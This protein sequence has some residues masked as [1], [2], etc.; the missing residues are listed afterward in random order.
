MKFNKEIKERIVQA[1]KEKGALNPCMRC[2]HPNFS[3]LDGFVNIPLAQEILEGIVILSGTQV[4]CAIV[5]CDN[6]GNISYHA[7]G[8]LGLIKKQKDGGQNGK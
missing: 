4:P 1:I 2:G 7:L 5:I 6:C 3:L 8:A